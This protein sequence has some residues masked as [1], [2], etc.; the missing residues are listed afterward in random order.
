VGEADRFEDRWSAY[1]ERGG[2][3]YKSRPLTP[4]VK[5]EHA[6]SYTIV[7][8]PGYGTVDEAIDHRGRI[9]SVLG[10]HQD[11]LLFERLGEEDRFKLT[12]LDRAALELR[13]LAGQ[14]R[15]RDGVLLDLGCYPDRAGEFEVTMWSREAERMVPLGLTGDPGTGRSNAA[16]QLM[17]G[18]SCS[19]VMNAMVVDQSGFREPELRRHA[20]VALGGA[21]QAGQV[22]SVLDGLVEARRR[23][24][25]AIN[26]TSLLPSPELPGWLVLFADV[27]ATLASPA[28]AARMSAF[29]RDSDHLG[30]WPVAVAGSVAP[31]E[32]GSQWILS[33]FSEQALAFCSGTWR[34]GA[35]G[36]DIRRASWPLDR[37]G[38]PVP[39]WATPGFGARRSVTMRWYLQPADGDEVLCDEEAAARGVIERCR[40]DAPVADIDAAVITDVLGKPVGGR[41]DRGLELS[42]GRPVVG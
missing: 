20:R 4:E 1:A 35:M 36:V 22:W 28:P 11:R 25:A 32:W 12:I 24:A 33:R 34:P 42:S 15:V 3:L 17:A 23:H 5:L 26:A 40:Q 37:R 27:G 19:G 18:A 38:V 31:Q 10:V 14:P 8:G 30:F 21:E 16:R 2:P 41:W 39:G 6:V 13:R 9:A 29:L 7:L